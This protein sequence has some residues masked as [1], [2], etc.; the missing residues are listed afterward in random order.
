M[1]TEEVRSIFFSSG[2]QEQMR[3]KRTCPLCKHL[4]DASLRLGGQGGAVNWEVGM[5]L[6]SPCYL[7]NIP[8]DC[9]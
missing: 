3:E 4:L 7:T 5:V 2:G 6:E 1:C 8:A 9:E